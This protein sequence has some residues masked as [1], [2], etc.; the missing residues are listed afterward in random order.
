MSKGREGK[1]EVKWLKKG[2]GGGGG[3]EKPRKN[4]SA[5]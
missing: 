1:R 3:G 2:G 5:V 4:V